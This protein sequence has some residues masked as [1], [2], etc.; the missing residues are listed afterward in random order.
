VGLFP[1]KQ[2]F[3]VVS[4]DARCSI[5]HFQ[6]HDEAKDFTFKCRREKGPGR[7]AYPVN[8]L[9]FHPT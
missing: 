6:A 8:S 1:N 4:A 5:Q 9:N 2:G 3:G 7:A